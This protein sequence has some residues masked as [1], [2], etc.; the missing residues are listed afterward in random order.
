TASLDL[1]ANGKISA[2]CLIFTMVCN[3]LPSV[4]GCILCVIIEPGKSVH[5]SKE[6]A[7]VHDQ[8]TETQ[9]IFADLLRNVFPDNLIVST[10]E[11]AHTKYR[12]AERNLSL[13]KNESSFITIIKEKEKILGSANGTNIIGQYV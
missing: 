9:D 4:L 10:F 5:I 6:F 2:V 11:Q 7:T 13:V 8:S 1:K 12:I 3:F